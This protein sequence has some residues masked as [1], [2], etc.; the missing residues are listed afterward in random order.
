MS[1]AMREAIDELRNKLQLQMNQV[2]ETKKAINTLAKSI[3]E[4][5]PYPD[6]SIESVGSGHIR[7]DQFYGKPLAGSVRE[8]LTLR[9]HAATVAEILDSLRRGGFDFGKGKDKFAEKNLRI[10]LSKNVAYFVQVKGSDAFGLREFYPDLKGDSDEEEK[11]K[12]KSKK[13]AKSEKVENVEKKKRGRPRKVK[14]EEVKK[15]E[16]KKDEPETK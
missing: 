10:S 9:G 4:A 15:E 16:E 12:K 8:Y 5:E 11:T 14:V 7:A 3:D 2:A 6:V 1:K 13:A